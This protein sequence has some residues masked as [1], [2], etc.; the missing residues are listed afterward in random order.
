MCEHVGDACACRLALVLERVPQ[1]HAMDLSR[2]QLRALPDSAFQLPHLTRLDVSRNRLT[3]LSPRVA[4]LQ[5]LEVLDVRANRLERLPE[6]ALLVLLKLR[7]VRVGGNSPE[8]LA[9]VRSPELRAKLVES[10]E[11]DV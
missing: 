1:L 7:E 3:E 4:E 6:S 8:L 2:N 9:S 11:E 5:A 10:T